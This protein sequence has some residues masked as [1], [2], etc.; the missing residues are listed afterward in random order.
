[1]HHEKKQIIKYV[2]LNKDEIRDKKLSSKY[3]ENAAVTDVKICKRL[4]ENEY[5]H[6]NNKKLR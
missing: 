3:T 2:W 6:L 1:M 5:Q 4:I